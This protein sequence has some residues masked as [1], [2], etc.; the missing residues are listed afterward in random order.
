MLLMHKRTTAVY[1]WWEHM[2][3][4]IYSG[5]MMTMLIQNE[6]TQKQQDEL[7]NMWT[8]RTTRRKTSICRLLMTIVQ[9]IIYL[10]FII[11]EDS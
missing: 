10:N 4:V 6:K 5:Q 11:V 2:V 8:L 7:R 9:F 1:W 3:M